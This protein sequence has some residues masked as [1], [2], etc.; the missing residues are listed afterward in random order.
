MKVFF[1]IFLILAS[2]AKAQIPVKPTSA[3]EKSPTIQAR[4]QVPAAKLVPN[5]GTPALAAQTPKPELAEIQLKMAGMAYPEME[6]KTPLVPLAAKDVTQELEKLKIKL[7]YR[8]VNMQSFRNNPSG[9]AAL[10]NIEAYVIKPY[11]LSL[12]DTSYSSVMAAEPGERCFL[13]AQVLTHRTSG[14]NRLDQLK[15]KSVAMLESKGAYQFVVES[16]LGAKEYVHTDDASRL[17]QMLKSKQVDGF[18]TTTFRIGTQTISTGTIGVWDGKESKTEPEIK[19]IHVTDRK[20]PCY[21]I[22]LPRNSSPEAFYRLITFA[23]KEPEKAKA[24]MLAI[25]GFQGLTPI[26]HEDWT[27][28]RNKY[29]RNPAYLDFLSGKLKLPGFRKLK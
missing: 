28:F 25:G 21:V 14:I 18:I 15:G 24:L 2:T 17:L 11:D 13:E 7:S 9:I 26:T 27:N 1:S 22:A 5:G 6:F 12:L 8:L 29:I 23:G 16:K 3:T 10:G 19:V 20:L 4:P